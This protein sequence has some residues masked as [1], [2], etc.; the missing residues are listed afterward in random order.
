M[1][2]NS[3]W[4]GKKQNMY[5]IRKKVGPWKDRKKSTWRE[6]VVLNRLRSGHTRRTYGFLMKNSAPQMPPICQYC[7]NTIVTVKHLLKTCPALMNEKMRRSLFRENDQVTLKMCIGEG[8]PIEQTIVY[9]KRIE[10]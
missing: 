2:W 9:L 7:N 1:A 3:E 5:E 4:E 6:E 8:A 10:A